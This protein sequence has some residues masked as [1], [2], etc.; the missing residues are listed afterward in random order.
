MAPF[1]NVFQSDG[2][3]SSASLKQQKKNSSGSDQTSEDDFVSP[4]R[5]RNKPP[6]DKRKPSAVSPRTTPAS[7]QS[8]DRT[9][10]LAASCDPRD[11]VREKERER[12][13]EFRERKK[14]NGSAVLQLRPPKPK[15]TPP[16][17][18]ESDLMA[19]YQINTRVTLPE[20][21]LNGAKKYGNLPASGGVWGRLKAGK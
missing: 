11:D 2:G 9:A 13:R 16:E 15:Q 21:C 7:R 8:L 5:T 1:L 18:S 12:W 6:A 19:C 3:N 17:P 10:W 14:S 4:S 20:R